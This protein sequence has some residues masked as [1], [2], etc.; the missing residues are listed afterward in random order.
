MC[1]A[2][3]GARAPTCSECGVVRACGSGSSGRR[4][5]HA[6][7][8]DVCGVT[9]RL[10]ADSEALARARACIAAAALAPAVEP[11]KEALVAGKPTLP[12]LTVRPVR[13]PSSPAKIAPRKA[14]APA[15][16]EPS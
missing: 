8:V 11:A 6:A 10:D 1:F 12:P 15:D 14:A 7:H 2:V 9:A 16:D 13:M 5:C 3:V 4:Q